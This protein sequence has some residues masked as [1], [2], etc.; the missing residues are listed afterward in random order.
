MTNTMSDLLQAL[1]G[2]AQQ[3]SSNTRATQ[4]YGDSVF[5]VPA[6]GQLLYN[7]PAVTSHNSGN[8]NRHVTTMQQWSSCVFCAWSVPRWYKS[9]RSSVVTVTIDSERSTAPSFPPYVCWAPN[10]CKTDIHTSYSLRQRCRQQIS[11]N[12]GKL[13]N[14]HTVQVPI[15]RII[16]N[17]SPWR[18]KSV[19]DQG[20]LRTVG[21]GEYL[22]R[23]RCITP[24]HYIC[25]LPEAIHTAL[26]SRE[27]FTH[28]LKH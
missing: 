13:S 17:E 27:H 2:T 3:T 14:L 5:F 10:L 12:G 23:R 25:N 15:I 19:I 20:C 1:L 8:A 6:H 18:D 28:Y 16:N 21:L 9:Q 22:A 26:T 24:M 11:Q 4:Q 7:A